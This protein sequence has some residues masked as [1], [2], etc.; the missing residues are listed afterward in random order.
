MATPLT[1]AIN[2][3]TTY[4][5]ETTGQSRTT[6]S[7]AVGDLVAGYGQ[8]GGDADSLLGSVTDL[9]Q[10]LR[11]ATL[12]S[13]SNF[14]TL[15]KTPNYGLAGVTG[16]TILVLPAITTIGN[17]T[18][19]D[20]TTITT[21]DIGASY[22]NSISAWLFSGSTSMNT[23]ILRSTSLVSCADNRAFNQTCFWSGGS[24][25]TIYVPSALLSSY[26]SASQWSAIN[27]YGTV[28]WAAIEGSQYE[29]Y[30]ADGTAIS[31]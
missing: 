23:L 8:G 29:N 18:F 2:A 13:K 17:Y 1:D 7:D 19:A 15:T 22:T 5:N 3:L 9:S 11:Y 6:L 21:Y 14:A 12:P 30:Y 20:N 31:S 26:P 16:C 28:T 4:A 27:G 25:G 24:G 10:G